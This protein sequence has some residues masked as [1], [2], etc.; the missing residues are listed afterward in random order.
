MIRRYLVRSQSKPLPPA[1]PADLP[2]FDLQGGRPAELRLEGT[3]KQA[4]E[5]GRTRLLVAAVSFALA[6]SLIGWRLV[7]LGLMTDRH[8]PSIA[9]SLGSEGL[10]T[11]RAD[12]VDRNGIVLATTL[13]T[14][15]LYANPRHVRDPEAAAERLAAVLPEVSPAQ[16]GA[17]LAS[18]RSFVWLQRNL[19]PRQQYAVNRL[20]IPGLYFQREHRR[21]YPHGALAP[22][23][24][25]FTGVD[26]QGLAGIEQSF[27]DVLRASAKPLQLSLD[28]RIQHILTEELAQAMTTFSAIGAAGVVMDARSGEVVALASL[29]S[30]DPAKPASAPADARFN[31]AS[32]G[33]YEMG[34]VFKIFTAAMALNE[35]VVALNDGYDTR[36]PIRISRFT[37][38]DFK[39][40]NRWLSIPEILMYSSNIGTVHMAMDAGTPVQQAFL[41]R[42]GLLQP[43]SIELPE[44][45]QPLIPSPWR[46]I[47]TMTISFGHGLA[48]SPVQL[49]A[50]M[51]AMVNGGTEVRPTLL[52]RD[53]ERVT[54]GNRLISE[55]TSA[56]VRQL[57]RLVVSQ[58]TA[59]KAN[60]EGYIVGGKTGTAEKLAGRGYS[61]N[62]R[63]ASF[64]GAFPMTAPRYVVFVMVDEPKPTKETHGYATGGWV[65]APVM[66]SIVERM[67]PL[68]GVMPRGDGEAMIADL[69]MEVN[70]SVE[71]RQLASN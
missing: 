17:R 25:G 5:T 67:G 13:P 65:A 12:I 50:A 42:L 45:G 54:A 15:S 61:R 10:E 68:V 21:F 18:D 62:S 2:S 8:E 53:P 60:A 33:I 38:R 35:G 1:T 31:R 28:I 19:T 57:M 32:L 47:N 9:R 14:A 59:R 4:L 37:I 69:L 49:T 36:K 70:K 30:F 71:G 22:H 40:K 51:S 39:P 3:R 55:S 7:D 16:L 64:V 58:G 27:D 56:T 6:F 34:S 41:K 20:G 66:R 26:N 24:V 63:I 23:V 44:V 11:G 43:A 48:V 46:E 29:P 52:K